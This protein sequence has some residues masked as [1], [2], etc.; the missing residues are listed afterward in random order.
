[1]PIWWLWR[2]GIPGG[3]ALDLSRVTAEFLAAAAAD[4]PGAGGRP[5]HAIESKTPHGPSGSEPSRSRGRASPLG[6]PGRCRARRPEV[7][8][9]ENAAA[10]PLRFTH[11]YLS[12]RISPV[13]P[14]PPLLSTLSAYAVEA[15]CATA[16]CAAAGWRCVVWPAAIP[17][18]VQVMTL[19]HPH[20]V[21][22]TSR[23]CPRSERPHARQQKFDSGHCVVLS[24]SFR[25]GTPGRIHGMG[26]DARP[27][28]GGAAAGCRPSGGGQGGT[29]QGRSRQSRDVA[30]VH[31]GSRPRPDR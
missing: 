15:S 19:F 3:D 24:D 20:G 11:T 12:A 17:G 29:A 31:S 8:C 2:K 26:A 13:R 5:K 9:D 25:L 18:A 27:G 4:S 30:C 16:C 10:R 22:A 14:P 7:G 1:M 21:A 23:L 28:G 6:A